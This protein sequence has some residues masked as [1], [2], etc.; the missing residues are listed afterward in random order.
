MLSRRLDNFCPWLK[1]Q[2][3]QFVEDMSRIFAA[4]PVL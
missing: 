1:D 2:A 4:A 3:F